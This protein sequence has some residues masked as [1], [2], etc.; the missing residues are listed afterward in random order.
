[1]TLRTARALFAALSLGI[2]LASLSGAARAANEPACSDKLFAIVGQHLG[3]AAFTMNR[4][5]AGVIVD[6]D[7]TEAPDK[8][9]QTLTVIAWERAV[10]NQSNLFIG[11]VDEA[12][13]QVASGLAT[14]FDEDP[15]TRLGAS[16]LRLDG[17]R[18]ELA[19]GVL[20]FGF[21]V[22]DI[23][24]HFC[25]DG[26][27]GPFRYLYV[28]EGSTIRPIVD[29][30]Q[31]A[32]WSYIGNR[33]TCRQTGKPERP[34]RNVERSLE[35]AASR[36]NGYADLRVTAIITSE[37]RKGEI[38]KTRLLRYNGSYYPS[39]DASVYDFTRR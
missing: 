28:Q 39:D 24:D 26:G 6:A 25:F 27:L 19:P 3:V 14:V 36:T 13:G 37:R 10:E 17:T 1:M 31:L 5:E 30:F 8:P 18:Y 22:K 9:G 4:Q 29:G 34:I 11:F 2:A 21:D 7:C 38:R 20:A 23:H 15:F 32:Q 12:R 33:S 16:S 35:V